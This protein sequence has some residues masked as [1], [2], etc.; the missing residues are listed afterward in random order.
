MLKTIHTIALLICF[1]MPVKSQTI[2]TQFIC[3]DGKNIKDRIETPPGFQR[4]KTDSNGYEDY[5]RNLPLKDTS[6]KVHYFNGKLKNNTSV[7]CAVI[8]MDLGKRDLQQC[9]DAVMRLRAEYLY[10]SSRY[11]EIKFNFVSDAKPRFYMDYAKGDYTYATFRKYMDYIFSYA[12]TRSLYDEMCRVKNFDSIEI[13]DVLI[14]KR[15][16]YG[17]AV[18]VV[19]M[20]INL[21]S[22]EKIFLLVQSY[23]PAQD[24]HILTNPINHELSPWYSIKSEN[25]IQTPEWLFYKK[26]LRRFCE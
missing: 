23:M 1:Y 2:E 19:D 18:T 15:N 13:G 11:S 24:I 20:A 8:D 16:P 9:A 25:E 10:S 4:I 22:G 5:L 3:S 6:A 14:Q 26:D 17:H 7:Y 21:K 12:N